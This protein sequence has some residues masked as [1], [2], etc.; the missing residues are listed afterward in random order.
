MRDGAL[1]HPKIVA[2]RFWSVSE[3]DRLRRDRVPRGWSANRYVRIGQRDGPNAMLSREHDSSGV[4]PSF[5]K[6]RER[7]PLMGWLSW[8]LDIGYDSSLYRH[9]ARTLRVSNARIDCSSKAFK[10]SPI[11]I[12]S[13]VKLLKSISNKRSSNT[14]EM[15]TCKTPVSITSIGMV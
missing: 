9:A 11:F 7:T 10:C 2:Q 6:A 8:K 15:T 3:D 14:L 13:L 12:A 1:P 4:N 5:N